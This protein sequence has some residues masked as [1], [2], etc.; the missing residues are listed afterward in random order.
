MAAR[1]TGGGAEEMKRLAARLRDADKVLR[2]ELRKALTE[3]SD[4]VVGA[5]REAIQASPSK[6]DGTLRGEVA[7]TV[8]ASVGTSGSQVTLAIVSRGSKMPEGK[9][10]LPSY[11]NDDKRWKHPVFGRA[12]AEIEAQV[13]GRGHGRGWTWVKQSSH[14]GGWFDQTISGRAPELR[15]SV[16]SAMDETARKLEG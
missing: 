3:A 16:E 9:G 2:K 14:A 5:V 4:P 7:R 6:H 13:G 8:S 11:L 10:N 1:V 12:I 15:R